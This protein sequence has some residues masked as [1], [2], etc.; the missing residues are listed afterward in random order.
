M[1][2]LCAKL[3]V[4][5][6]LCVLLL[7][8]A[9]AAQAIDIVRDNVPVGHLK[10]LPGDRAVL[11]LDINP[12]DTLQW[13]WDEKDGRTGQFSSQLIWTDVA[14]VEHELSPEPRGRTV[15]SFN[16][17]SD[18]LGARLEW[19]NAGDVEGEILWA[20]HSTA[21]FWKR[22]ELFL[23][24]MLPLFLLVGAFYFGRKMDRRKRD[25]RA[26]LAGR[27]VREVDSK[28]TLA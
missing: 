27:S 12:K 21:W 23:P 11:Y 17:P 9:G 25:A 20:Y 24:A 19:H 2:G 3:R 4:A 14:G 26:E 5:F 10:V 13:T 6:W 8:C 15:G 7:N 18:L 22:P 1:R 16:A 28:E